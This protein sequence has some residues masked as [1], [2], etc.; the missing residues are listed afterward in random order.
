MRW[1]KGKGLNP[2]DN[3]DHELYLKKMHET[4]VE[5][6]TEKLTA[7]CEAVEEEERNKTYLEVLHHSM[8]CRKK[9]QTFMVR[10]LRLQIYSYLGNPEG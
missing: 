9:I 1:Q 6:I 7:V 10:L 5:A 8:Y 4:M 2:A 3:S